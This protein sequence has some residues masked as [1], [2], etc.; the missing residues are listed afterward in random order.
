M[1]VYD[2]LKIR[3]VTKV[4][5]LELEKYIYLYFSVLIEDNN[6]LHNRLRAS[7]VNLA[8]NLDLT[9]LLDHL[10]SEEVITILEVDKVRAEKGFY[11]QN[12]CL[13]YI[14]QTKNNSQIEKFIEGLIKTNQI[15]LAKQL[16]PNG[17]VQFA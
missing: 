4:P 2:N 14:L 16:D 8:E 11:K 9:Q 15:I 6:E 17:K 10:L 12:C 1:K 7:H 5:V 3:L 13:L